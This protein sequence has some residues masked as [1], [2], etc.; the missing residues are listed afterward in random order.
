M[1]IRK[2]G[3]NGV[4]TDLSIRGSSFEQ[5]LLLVNGIRMADSQTGHNS[6]EFA[7][8]LATVEK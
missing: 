6:Y 4:Q 8:D 5:V 1:D 7:F 2:R 3:A